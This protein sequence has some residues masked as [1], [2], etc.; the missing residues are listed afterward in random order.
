[1]GGEDE[2]DGTAG[3]EGDPLLLGM[4]RRIR[5]ARE[6]AGMSF[7][8]LATAAG[9][10][11]GYVYRMEAGKQNASIRS[12]ARISVALS[13]TISAL[14]DGVDADPS[15]LG[16]RSYKWREGADPR[17]PDRPLGKRRQH[18]AEKG[19]AAE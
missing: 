4:G 3:K 5:E 16:T 1:M 13:T 19:D 7:G 9:I 6:A 8:E 14:M 18:A 12:I 2:S 17:D 10:S 15:T 11:R